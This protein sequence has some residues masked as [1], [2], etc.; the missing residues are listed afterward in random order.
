MDLYGFMM[1]HNDLYCFI[2]IY[3][4]DLPLF[5]GWY[6]AYTHIY[7]IHIRFMI[8]KPIDR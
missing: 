6:I 7:Y 2:V 8:A 3:N 4:I 5:S 1:V